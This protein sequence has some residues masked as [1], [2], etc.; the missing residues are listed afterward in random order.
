MSATQ[1]EVIHIDERLCDGCGECV[2]SCAEGAIAIVD[3]KARPIDDALCDGL[4]ACIGHCPQG[5]I[6]VVRGCA[7]PD[8]PAA[9]GLC[10]EGGWSAQSGRAAVADIPVLGAQPSATGSCPGAKPTTFSAGAPFSRGTPGGSQLR[11]WPVQLH[12]ISPTAPIYRNA[13]VLLAA[14]CSAFAVADFHASYLSGR[15]L[16]VACPKLDAGQERYVEK[17]AAMIDATR[18]RSLTVL[19][20]EVP[21]CGGLVQLVRRALDR[22]ERSLPVGVV[23]V[24]RAGA[25][26]AERTLVP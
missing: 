20:M 8:D 10:L 15:A 26:V 4:G 9:A 21:C 14:D 12:L 1:R 3:G 19:V 2:P 16:A 22:C 17:L 13:D 23:V 18:V 25:V 6:T 5:A 7:V 24:S 11:H